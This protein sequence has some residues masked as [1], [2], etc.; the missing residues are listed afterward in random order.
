[1]TGDIELVTDEELITVNSFSLDNVVWN[2]S[3]MPEDISDLTVKIRYRT[4][5]R[6]CRVTRDGNIWH[7]EAPDGVFRAVT[8][9]QSAVFYQNELLLGG[10]VIMERD[11]LKC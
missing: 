1:L 11:A 3:V 7:V 10:G 5:D 6:A 2:S 9:G 8:P 4:T